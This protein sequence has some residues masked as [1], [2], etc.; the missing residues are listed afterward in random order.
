MLAAQDEH[1]LRPAQQLEV[2]PTALARCAEAVDNI[3]GHLSVLVDDVTTQPGCK[4]S[5]KRRVGDGAPWP[6][7]GGV[8]NRDCFVCPEASSSIAC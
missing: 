5:E 7:T 4:H 3:T 1:R 6:I 8:R 2:S